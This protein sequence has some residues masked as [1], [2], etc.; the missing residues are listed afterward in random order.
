MLFRAPL[1]TVR[2]RAAGLP[3]SVWGTAIA[4]SGIAVTLLGIVGAATWGSERILALK[5]SQSVA[6]SGYELTFD[7]IVQ[8]GGRNF[9]GQVARFTVRRDGV[10]VGVMEPT[11]RN[12]A[13]RNMTTNVAALLT[14]GTGQLYLSLGDTEASGAL[15]IRLYYKPLVNLIWLGSIIMML[16][17]GLSLSDRRLRVGAPR[18]AARKPALQPAE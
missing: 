17:G 18:P 8:E 2:T 6:I 10:V 15:A 11:K 14:R 13:A 16:G 5:P 12:F 3:R 9:E 4:H 1:A 7:G